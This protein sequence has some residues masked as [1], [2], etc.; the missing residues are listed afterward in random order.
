MGCVGIRTPSPR[1]ILGREDSSET[2]ST[3][4]TS[5]PGAAWSRS[6]PLGWIFPA[7]STLGM[8]VALR[9]P[10][11]ARLHPGAVRQAAELRDADLRRAGEQAHVVRDRQEVEPP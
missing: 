3:E 11:L 8:S 10:G 6:M 9:R 2:S 7:T 4:F 5:T 1:S